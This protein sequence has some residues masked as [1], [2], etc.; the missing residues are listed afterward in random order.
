[1]KTTPLVL[2][3]FVWMMTV[4]GLCLA[5]N[6]LS[7]ERVT[8]YL[9]KAVVGDTGMCLVDKADITLIGITDLVPGAQAEVFY[10]YTYEL[11]CQN[12]RRSDKGQGVLQAARL[13]SGKWIDRKTFAMIE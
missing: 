6:D 8:A 7:E 2:L 12:G 5:G 3:A 11:R 4:T 1:M 9:K 13:R 10:T